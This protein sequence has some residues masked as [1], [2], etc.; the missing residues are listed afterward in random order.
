MLL[1]KRSLG[2]IYS[3][4]PLSPETM[5]PDAHRSRGH[6]CLDMG[7]DE[8]TVGRPHPM[9]DLSARQERILAEAE[10]PETA[11][12]LIDIVIGYGAHHDPGVVLAQTI[13][14]AKTRARQ[15]GRELPVVAS[16]C[17]T[18]SDPQGLEIQQRALA[19]AG[20]VLAPSNAA[21]ARSHRLL[22]MTGDDFHT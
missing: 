8:F 9:I 12:V 7:A 15:A 5:L 11:C 19:E 13:K 4:T 14:E 3:N 6:T 22:Q 20:V 17:G 16:I 21:A 1:A 2:N 10:D 18:L